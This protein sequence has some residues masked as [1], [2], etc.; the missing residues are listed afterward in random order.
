M[1]CSHPKV[2][3]HPSKF[4]NILV[5]GEKAFSFILEGG[6]MNCRICNDELPLED[7]HL[8]PENKVSIGVPTELVD[9]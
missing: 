3:V 9:D 8:Y 1:I 7:M 6:T 4:E 5:D 2:I